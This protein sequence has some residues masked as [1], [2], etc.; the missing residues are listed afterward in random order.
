MF[1]QRTIQLI[2]RLFI[3]PTESNYKFINYSK[4][5]GSLN[6]KDA[7]SKNLLRADLKLVGICCGNCVPNDLIG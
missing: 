4:V 3:M 6:T 2:I 5:S 1:Y 7:F